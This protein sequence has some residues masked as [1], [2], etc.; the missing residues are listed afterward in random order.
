MYNP[1]PALTR[2]VGET[3]E[4][5]ERLAKLCGHQTHLLLR[6]ASDAQSAA[7]EMW[8]IAEEHQRAAA[9]LNGGVL[10]GIGEDPFA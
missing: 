6:M 2:P 8:R 4:E 3:F 5:L 9:E 7:V 10:P 1:N